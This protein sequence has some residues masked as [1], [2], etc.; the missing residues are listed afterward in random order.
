M[1]KTVYT[2]GYTGFTTEKFLAT[3]KHYNINVVIDVRS[4]P[5]SER[6]ADYNKDN[7]EKLLKE[8]GIYYRNYVTEFGARQDNNTFYA[9]D[10]ILDFELFARS[11]QFQAGVTKIQNSLEKGYSVVLLC[12]EK[13]PIQCHRTILVARAFH[14]L[15]YT[16]LHLLPEQ[17]TL[18][19]DQIELELLNKYF[20]NRG[21]ISFFSGCNMSDEEC[22]IEAYKMQ[23][24]KIGYKAEGEEV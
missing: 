15:G 14:N 20:P 13:N 18:T 12:A 3:L 23:N 11:K 16:V 10:G 7:I 1:N 19:H 17:K 21:Q 8:N 2:I 24:K 4:S 22:L 6:Y 5:Y 9:D